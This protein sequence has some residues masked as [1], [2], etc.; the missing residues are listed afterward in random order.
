[1]CPDQWYFADTTVIT[2]LPPNAFWHKSISYHRGRLERHWVTEWS[3]CRNQWRFAVEF[4]MGKGL[5]RTNRASKYLWEVYFCCV[6]FFFFLS[7]RLGVFLSFFFFG[8]FSFFLGGRGS[9]RLEGRRR[10][11]WKQKSLSPPSPHL[12]HTC[13]MLSN[14]LMPR[15]SSRVCRRDCSLKMKS[16]AAIFLEKVPSAPLL[17]LLCLLAPLYFCMSKKDESKGLSLRSV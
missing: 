1:M 4:R 6:F 16:S 13:L 3:Q 9:G 7:V 5:K 14:D 2:L 10:E 11:E 17:A 12:T 15:V 8:E